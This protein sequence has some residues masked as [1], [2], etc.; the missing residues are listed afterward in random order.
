MSSLTTVTV[1]NGYYS[2]VDKMFKI[3]RGQVKQ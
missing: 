2:V 1:A 3:L